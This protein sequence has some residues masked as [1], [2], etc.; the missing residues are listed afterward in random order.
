M[1]KVGTRK[2]GDKWQYY[3]EGA[4]VNGKRKQIVKS[5]FKSSKEAYSAGVKALAEYE[6]GGSA[7][8]PSTVSVSD[9]FDEWLR[10]YVDVNLKISTKKTYVKAI[11]KQIKPRIGEYKLKSVTPAVVQG[12]LNDLY[13]DGKSGSYITLI[14][15][16]MRAAFEYA[17]RP[18]Q[19]LKTNPVEYAKTPK[20]S[21]KQKRRELV[22][23]TMFKNI[24]NR[25][26]DTGFYLPL[27]IGYYAGL[28]I[29]EVY[30]L[31]WD[32]IDFEANTIYVRKQLKQDSGKWYFSDLK[33]EAS[34]RDV[35][36]GEKLMSAIKDEYETQQTERTI[37]GRDYQDTWNLVNAK[38]GGGF[39]TPNS[40]AYASR[41]IRFKLGYKNFDFH[42]LRHT[43]AT[44]L[45]EAGANIKDV[46]L[47]L[48]HSNIETTLQT[49]AH[50]TEKMSLNTVDIFERLTAD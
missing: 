16:I 9:Y 13:L 38:R 31:T 22:S 35:I 45:I 2:R 43:H 21:P 47:R 20:G 1:G 36:V 4:K 33:N 11:N 12:L 10:L 30:G 14:R 29:G 42:S 39:Y 28:R 27:M 32:N 3:F 49:Y 24:I 34:V 7:I 26:E 8:E 5:G 41:V 50:G 37:L 48:G 46:S 25:F 23:R 40:F 6:N 15:V 19:Y 17:I 18:M 44:M